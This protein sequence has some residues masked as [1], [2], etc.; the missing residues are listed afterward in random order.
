M[1]TY[2]TKTTIVYTARVADF[3]IAKGEKLLGVRPD[4]KNPDKNVFVFEKSPTMGEH[5]Q[6]AQEVR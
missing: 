1:N 4:L 6:E 5:L 3:L 2:S